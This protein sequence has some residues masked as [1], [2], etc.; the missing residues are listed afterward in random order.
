MKKATVCFMWQPS[1]AHVK[2]FVSQEEA[3][4]LAPPPP[5]MSSGFLILAVLLFCG[6]S[7]LAVSYPEPPSKAK[8]WTVI[9]LLRVALAICLLGGSL[10]GYLLAPNF[11]F[12]YSLCDSALRLTQ[13]LVGLI[14]LADARGAWG[15]LLLCLF[16]PFAEIP[17]H[18]DALGVTLLLLMAPQERPTD[19]L[20]FVWARG[21]VGFAFVSLALSE[22]LIHPEL[23][24]AFLQIHQWNFLSFLGVSDGVFALAIGAV[25]VL[26]GL[27]LMAGLYPR[28][29]G[30]FLISIMTTTVFLAGG[31]ELLG[32]MPCMVFAYALWVSRGQGLPR[33]RLA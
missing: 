26:L 17:E 8:D 2:W 1:L 31:V 24:M 12:D 6:L 23:S 13:A 15:V 3:A 33:Q 5:W 25:E 10:N 27:M 20:A 9:P 29:C 19:S 32:H 30:L 11:A 14:L 28:L 22:K 18:A 21:L 7:R 4:Q 16:V